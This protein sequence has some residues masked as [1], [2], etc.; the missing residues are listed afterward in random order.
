MALSEELCSAI[1]DLKST[2]PIK[3]G[4]KTCGNY[5]GRHNIQKQVILNFMVHG[6]FISSFKCL[7]YLFLIVSVGQVPNT[8][9][10]F[11]NTKNGVSG[12]VSIIDE[13]TL[14]LNDFTFDG[15]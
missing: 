14:L 1:P 11:E 13:K 10:V 9:G 5:P 4:V 3:C 6:K 15:K 12:S 7:I 2:C 8:I